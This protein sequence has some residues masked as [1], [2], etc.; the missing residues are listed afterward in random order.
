MVTTRAGI[1]GRL[2]PTIACFLLIAAGTAGADTVRVVTDR[3]LIWNSPS[4]VAVILTQVSKDAVLEVVRR[5]GDWYEVV[6]PPASSGSSQSVGYVL[7]SQVT[8]ASS[9]PRSDRAEAAARRAAPPPRPARTGAATAGRTAFLNLSGIHQQSG[10]D[11]T[12]RTPAFAD[13]YVEPGSIAGAY[14]RGDAW[15]IDVLGGQAVSRRVGVGLGL[16][17]QRRDRSAA[18]AAEVPH[19]FFFNQLR[20]ATFDTS[21]LRRRELAVHIPVVWM[22]SMSGRTRALLFGGPS[23][24]HITQDVVSNLSLAET[25]PYDQVTVTDSTQ[26]ELSSTV[27]GFHVGGDLAYMFTPG[28]GVGGGVRYSS[29]Q[30]EF[31][32]DA[33]ATGSGRAGGLEVMAGIRFRF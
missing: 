31:G 6:L 21:P 3:A 7:A 2:L 5:V 20:P 14:G 9:G 25:Y 24:F 30:K 22:P 23:I 15:K 29:G 8:I 10:T 12:R 26:T 18:I 33:D 11:L 28:V 32:K 13:H 17:Y 27:V 4:G 16:S 19:P 1:A